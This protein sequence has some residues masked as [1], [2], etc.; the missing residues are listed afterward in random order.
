MVN[1]QKNN[2][3]LIVGS[4]ALDTIKTPFGEVKDA[5]GGSATYFSVAA[6][7]FSPVRI[8]AVVGKDFPQRHISLLQKRR[9]DTSGLFIDKKGKTF[10]WRGYYEYDLSNAHTLETQLNVFA[11]FR[12]DLNPQHRSSEY[13][14]LGNIDPVLQS[15]VLEQ[16]KSPRLIGADT[17]NFWIEGKPSDLKNMIRKI[18]VLIINEAEAR[19]FAHEKNLVK[20]ARKII[21]W[22]PSYLVIKRGEY[23]AL[24]FADN[25]IFS[26]PAYPLE[27]ISDP[28]GAGD[29]FAGGFMGYLASVNA[30]RGD[31]DLFQKMSRA[32]I[33]GSVMASFN[34]ESFSLTRLASLI[35]RDISQRY[36]EFEQ[37]T[38]F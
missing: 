37:L 31:K 26:A 33:Y 30:Q 11:S 9:I 20:A 16:M 3:I 25:K 19:E 15:E 2:N 22:G 4:V 14:F 8:V 1:K 27:N 28:T 23:G 21:S 6:S 18:D 10:R 13:L 29:S 38:C 5:L 12:P 36:K 32:V 35:N 17:M 34:V 7:Y 24:L